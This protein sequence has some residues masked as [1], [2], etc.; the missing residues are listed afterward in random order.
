MSELTLSLPTRI[1]RGTLVEFQW[2]ERTELGRIVGRPTI[3]YHAPESATEYFVAVEFSD[4]PLCLHG[5]NLK[6]DR[7]DLHKRFM[8]CLWDLGLHGDRKQIQMKLGLPESTKDFSSPHYFLA[9]EAL[10]EGP[11]DAYLNVC[12]ARKIDPEAW[13]LNFCERMIYTLKD[14]IKATAVLLDE[15]EYEDE[16]KVLVR[17]RVLA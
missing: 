7:S 8:A 17:E 11:R 3:G 6:I 13:G 1:I 5:D 10:V 12:R 4:T 2:G 15:P 14:Y 16:A 9:I